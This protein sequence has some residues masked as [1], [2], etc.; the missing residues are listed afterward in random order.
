MD[1]SQVTRRQARIIKG[2]LEPTLDY[3][4]RLRRRMAKRGFHPDD[5]LMKLV[6]DTEMALHKLC[7][8][9]LI[10]T[11]DGPTALPPPPKST[12]LAKGALEIEDRQQRNGQR[13]DKSQV[14]DGGLLRMRSS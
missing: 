4:T 8:D 6:I 9:L 1:S 13:V 3:V 12:G 7:V 2:K 11:E 14:V 5:E 10:L